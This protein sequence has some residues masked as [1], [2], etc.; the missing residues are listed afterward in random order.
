V[1]LFG[2]PPEIGAKVVLSIAILGGAMMCFFGIRLFRVVLCVAGLVIGATV[3]AYFAVKLTLPAG[4]VPPPPTYAA[5]M[6]AIKTAPSE[7]FVL[8]WAVVG[9]VVGALL[10]LLTHQVGV[11]LLGAW[12]GKMVAELTTAGSS[13]QSS[14]MVLAI[15]V[16]IG[17]VLAIV[18]RKTIIIVSTAFNGAFALMFGMYA[19][20]KHRSP[21]WAAQDLQ[22]GGHDLY[23]LLGCTAVM[24]LIGG[25]VQFATA[26]SE[27][28]EDPVYK[29][30][31]GKK[32][33]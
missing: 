10:S 17:G 9:G 33:G 12:L 8:V 20:L 23:V 18:M 6:S 27:K 7:T 28:K 22:K 21:E 19:L 2:M 5:L 26:P 16:L 24:A 29:K 1:S 32:G 3:A 25:Y 13:N 15:L 4:E 31:K 11:F 30:V 14:M